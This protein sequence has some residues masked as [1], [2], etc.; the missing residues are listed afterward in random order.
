MQERWI[1]RYRVIAATLV[2][3]VVA[4]VGRAAWQGCCGDTG[5]GESGPLAAFLPEVRAPEGV[6]VRVEVLNATTTPRLAQAATHLLRDRGF[7]VVAI[8]NHSMRRDSTLV[9]ARTGHVDWAR[10]VGAVLGS[11]AVESRP[12]TSRYVDVSVLLGADWT[13]PTQ[14]FH[15]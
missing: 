9:L 6:R 15:P 11:S 1:R 3:I 12:D 7:D 2:A 5:A 8:G 4:L 14:P 10:L 13:R